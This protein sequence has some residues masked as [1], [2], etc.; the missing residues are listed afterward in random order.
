M[1]SFR[2]ANKKQVSK[3]LL[4]FS[5]IIEDVLIR[6]LEI[7][8]ANLENHAKLTAGYED[9]T[10]NL[11]GSIGGVVLKDG[12]IVSKKGFDS[13]G[14]EGNTTGIEFINSLIGYNTKGFV[15]ILVAGMEYATYQEN[16]H[17]N[18]VLKKSELKMKR[19]LPKVLSKLKLKID[20]IK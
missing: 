7:L 15:I 8:V 20:K 6:E 10:S 16:F 1:N 12:R 9:Q 18:N 5:N 4:T 3:Y 13:G 14:A 19:E 2:M 17:N 11:K